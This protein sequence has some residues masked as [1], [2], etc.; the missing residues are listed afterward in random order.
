MPSTA[1]RSRSSSRLSKPDLP[2]TLVVAVPSDVSDI[3]SAAR[4]CSPLFT[5]TTSSGLIL[6]SDERRVRRGFRL[7]LTHPRRNAVE[8]KINNHVLR[9]VIDDVAIARTRAKGRQGI[10]LVERRRHGQ[11][12][13]DDRVEDIR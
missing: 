5:T 6:L 12:M 13:T 4:R 9:W 7:R 3:V 11:T 1:A 8:T 2:D 10:E